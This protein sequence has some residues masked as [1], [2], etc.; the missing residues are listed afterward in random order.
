MVEGKKRVS[1]RREGWWCGR[2]GMRDGE[3]SKRINRGKEKKKEGRM[4]QARDWN[5]RGS[6]GF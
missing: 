6:W 5:S 3:K 4:R 1:G 2:E